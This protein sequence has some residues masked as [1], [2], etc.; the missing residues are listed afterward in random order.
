MGEKK[1]YERATAML[2]AA[3]ICRELKPFCARL[4]VAGSLRRRKAMVGD[5]EIVFVPKF[6]E[7]ADTLFET[8]QENMAAMA[9]A[10]LKDTG[11][12][13]ERIGAAGSTSWGPKNKLAV[14]VASR[15]PV[16]L[17]ETSEPCWFNYL[18][19]RTGGA[20]SNVAVAS[21]AQRLGLKWNPYDVGFTRAD[22]SKIHVTSERHVFEIV[23]LPYK[24]PWERT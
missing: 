2:V 13:T 21:A 19:C 5:V 6:T 8:K 12:L 4:I 14:H 3:E 1:R 23:G 15:M 24:E 22:G 9:I 10:R 16:D 17:F 11:I 18:T 7:V 20:E